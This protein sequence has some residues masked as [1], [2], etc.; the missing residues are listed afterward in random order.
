MKNHKTIPVVFVIV[1]LC[2][3]SIERN[4]IR[5]GSSVHGIVTKTVHQILPQDS[6]Y[7]WDV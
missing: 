3:L 5:L 6:G 1:I 7:Y 2:G 4:S